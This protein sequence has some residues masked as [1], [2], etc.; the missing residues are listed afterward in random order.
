MAVVTTLGL[1][2]KFEK[3]ELS[4]EDQKALIDAY[5]KANGKDAFLNDFKEFEAEQKQKE[6]AEAQNRMF[7]ELAGMLGTATEGNASETTNQVL[8]A[9]K[10][11]KDT[12]AKLGAASQGDTPQDTVNR[13]LRASGP[14]TKDF[15]FGIQHPMFAAN[16]RYNRIAIEHAITGKADE[17]DRKT[18]MDD[19][20]SYAE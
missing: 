18:L 1:Q 11:L 5:N 10:D 16:K 19:A 17:R 12:V 4:A 13:S 15:A 7:Q 8:A 14:H 2:A 9:V 3:K 6:D 20:C